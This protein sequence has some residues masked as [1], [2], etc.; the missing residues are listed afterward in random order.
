MSM[1]K[2]KPKSMHDDHETKSCEFRNV[3]CQTIVAL[4]RWGTLKQENLRHG[5]VVY[6]SSGRL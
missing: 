2:T 6:V 5:Q 4:A 1:V 3:E